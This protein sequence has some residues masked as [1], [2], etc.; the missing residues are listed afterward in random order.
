MKCRFR[1]SGNL[2][3]V[4]TESSTFGLR[5]SIFLLQYTNKNKILSSSPRGLDENASILRRFLGG[6]MTYD[7]RIRCTE[8]IEN[9]VAAVTVF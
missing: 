8:Y 2:S 5:V 4:E 7:E 6:K 9:V 1:C 3:E